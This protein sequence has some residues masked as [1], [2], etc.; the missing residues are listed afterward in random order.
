MRFQFLIIILLSIVFIS[1]EKDDAD[2]VDTEQPVVKILAPD[3]T[4]YSSG[5]NLPVIAKITENDQ[6]HEITVQI[7]NL[8][9]SEIVFRTHTHNHS[10]STVYE[11]SMLLPNV[12]SK[13]LY[14]IVVSATDHVGNEASDTVTTEVLH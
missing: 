11:T 2:K 10:R 5:M 6:L 14:E 9:Q 1:C 13:Q 8:T 3:T 12:G 7:T 4:I